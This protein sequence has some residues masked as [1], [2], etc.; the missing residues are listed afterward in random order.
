MQIQTFESRSDAVEAAVDALASL[1]EG[2]AHLFISGGSSFEVFVQLDEQLGDQVASQINLYQVDERYG[3]VGHKD[4]NWT[5]MDGIDTERYASVHPVLQDDS[6]AGPTAE[7]YDVIVSDAIE[8]DA[9][10]VAILGVGDDHHVSGVKPMPE[11]EFEALFS[12][13]NFV[14]YEWDDFSRL[15]TTLEALRQ[16]D[17]LV[18]FASGPAKAEVIDTL[19]LDLPEHQSPIHGL[20]KHPNIT[21]MYSKE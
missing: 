9:P 11:D 19:N 10:A 14:D 17:R 12:D 6:L 15:T 13:A 16:F 2:P 8:D 20:L 21:I 18:V 3:P 4:S 1:D 5:M 7:N